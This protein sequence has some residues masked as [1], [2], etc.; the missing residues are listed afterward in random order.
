MARRT[1]LALGVVAGVIASALIV[2]APVGAKPDAKDKANGTIQLAGAFGIQTV[3]MNAQSGPD[4]E[5]ARGSLTF[6]DSEF[7]AG[8]TGVVEFLMVEGNRATACGTITSSTFGGGFAVG[9]RFIQYVRDVGNGS[10]SGA[11]DSSATRLIVSTPTCRT[12]SSIEAQFGFGTLNTG[13]NWTVV[14]S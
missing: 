3:S 8:F 2:A 1:K 13:G 14:D 6:T 10:P 7:N 5:N 12:P 9:S 4:G 11:G